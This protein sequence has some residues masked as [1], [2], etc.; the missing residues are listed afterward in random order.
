MLGKWIEKSRSSLPEIFAALQTKKT[1][2]ITESYKNVSSAR[3]PVAPLNPYR[4][5]PQ[6]LVY[7]KM[8]FQAFR[9]PSEGHFLLSPFDQDTLFGKR[10]GINHSPA[11]RSQLN[12]DSNLVWLYFILTLLALGTEFKHHDEFLNLRQGLL[13][14]NDGRFTE[15]DFK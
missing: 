9:L 15:E 5:R 6:K 10:E 2:D 1:Y 7:D 13:S 3:L 4:K 11:V 12:L 8:E 14:S